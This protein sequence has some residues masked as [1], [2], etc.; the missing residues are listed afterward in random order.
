MQTALPPPTT[1]VCEVEPPQL[2]KAV[3]TA[4][5]GNGRLAELRLVRLD[6]S[7]ACAHFRPEEA[8]AILLCIEEA[9]VEIVAAQRTLLKGRDFRNSFPVTAKHVTKI[10]G[11][12]FSQGFPILSLVLGSGLRL[13]FS[14]SPAAIPE[15][16][17]WLKTLEA[18]SRAKPAQRH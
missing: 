11:G 15:I 18:A 1:E 5:S 13:D 9:L 12:I 16:V 8:G 14:P 4:L 2:L 10:Q 3:G 17:T 6:D 7:V